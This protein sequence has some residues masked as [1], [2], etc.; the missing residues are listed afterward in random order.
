MDFDKIEI[1]RDPTIIFMGTPEFSV[2]VLEGLISKYKVRAIVTQPEK[3]VGRQG[4][5]KLSPVKEVA[6]KYN[7]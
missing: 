1:K 7:I 5:V 4:D 2:P 6:L 3:P